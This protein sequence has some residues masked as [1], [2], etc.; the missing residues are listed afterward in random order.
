M[1]NP[2]PDNFLKLSKELWKAITKWKFQPRARQVFDAIVFLTYGSFPSVKHKQISMSEIMDLTDLNLNQASKSF[3][4][5][6]KMNIVAKNGD[7]YP[8]SIGINKDYDSWKL[9]PKTATPKNGKGLR[10]GGKNIVAKNGD[11][12]RQKRRQVGTP[13]LYIIKNKELAIDLYE[14]YKNEIK[15]LRKTRKAAL[16]NIEFYLKEFSFEDLKGA[17]NIYKTTAIKS[18]PQYRKNPSNFFGR[19]GDS[20]RYFEDYLSGNYEKPEDAAPETLTAADIE[21]LGE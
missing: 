21:K 6:L 9:S 13:T 10:G 1:A 15:P 16:K 5:L 8:R 12:S 14:F 18:D 2:Q 19:T 3:N 4:Q 17:I 11:N 7:Y 20:E